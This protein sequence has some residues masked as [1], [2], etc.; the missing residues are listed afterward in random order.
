MLWLALY[1]SQLP[2]DRQQSDDEVMDST[3]DGSRHTPR[4]VVLQQGSRRHILACNACALAAGVRAGMALKN[5]YALIPDLLV[6]DYDETAQAAHLEQLTLWALQYSSKV[7]PEPPDTL[8][9]EIQASLKLFGGLNPLLENIGQQLRDQKISV[10]PG[11]AP[12]PAAARL[13]TRAGIR[14]AVRSPQQLKDILA[15]VNVTYLPLNDFTFKGLRQSGIHTLGELQKIPPAALTRRF[16]RHC[17]D[18]LYKLDGRLPDPRTPYQASETFSQSIDL[19]L[20]APDT[21]ALGFPL[22]RL[23][24]SLGGFLKA[25]DL[26]IRHLDIHLYHHRLKPHA[27]ALKFLTATAD[28]SH[29]LRVATE[30]LGT[31]TLDAPVTRLAVTSVELAFMEREGRDLFHKSQSQNQSVEQILD[32]LVARLG[33][34]AVYTALPEDDHRPEKAWLT[35]LFN[36]R[37][38]H[39]PWPARPLWLLA[40]PRLLDEPITLHTLPE[41]IE[42]GWWDE[43]DVRR[44]Y[45]IA[46]NEQGS[47]YWL[48]RLRHQPDQWWIHGLFA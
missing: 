25:R 31:L 23:L 30:R 32:K 43:T 6:S 41:R 26:G 44:D 7:V 48:Y 3:A 47:Y 13:F 29:L 46:S 42:N 14:K 33:K 27:V 16:G 21:Q 11:I 38:E 35:V 5:A 18:I 15:T 17:T 28:M 20:E 1:F 36:E 2:I 45:F 12:T 34:E 9:I 40:E 4:A 37:H 8:L 24:G 10:S 39:Q 19:P 22:K